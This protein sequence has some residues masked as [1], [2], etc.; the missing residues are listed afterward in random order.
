MSRRW[1]RW[2]AAMGVAAALVAIA[3]GTALRARQA[4]LPS[5]QQ[6]V[7]KSIEAMG[8]AAAFKAV[9]SM[10]AHG[11]FA[12][13]AQQISGALEVVS[14]RPNKL[15]TKISLAGLGEVEEG[16]DGKVGWS[17][18][19]M[20]GPS[21][22]TGRQLLERADESWFDAPLHAPDYVK[23]MTVVGQEE[24]DGRDAYRVKVVTVGGNEQF[25]LFEVA[26]G[27]L[28]GFEATRATPMGIVPTTGIFRDFRK[29]GALTF[30]ATLIQRALG[31]EQVL[32][33]TSYEFDAVPSSAFDLPPA[34]KALIK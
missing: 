10:R 24:F 16:Y 26:S 5:A 13:T 22:V 7:D 14:A 11:T 20:S 23:E 31:L 29:F 18:D 1:G 15:V 19:P 25:E 32:T 21:L 8:G 27:L 12:L 4:A 28:I 9:K 34:I 30:P 17:I 2:Q 33:F 6:I 3:G